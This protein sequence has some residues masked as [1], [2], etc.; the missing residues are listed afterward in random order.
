MSTYN[1][2]NENRSE[3]GGWYSDGQSPDE[4]APTD[5]TVPEAGLRRQPVRCYLKL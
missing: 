3:Q 4:T 1:D 5:S 2:M